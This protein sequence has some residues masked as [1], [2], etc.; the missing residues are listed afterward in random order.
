MLLELSLIS[1]NSFIPHGHCY[2]WKSNLVALHILSD[3]MIG[4]AYYVI[5]P[6]LIYFVRRREDLVFNWMFLLFGAF[7][8]ACGTT[9]FLEV[10]TLWH[11]NYWFT[12]SVKLLTGIISLYTAAKL[13]PLIP[14]ALELPS[15]KQMEIANKQLQQLNYELTEIKQDLEQRVVERTAELTDVVKRLEKE[16]K[17]RQQVEQALRESSARF[18][19][20]FD[21]NMIGIC[22]WKIDGEILEANDAFLNILGYSRNDFLIKKVSWLEFTAPEYALSDQKAL[23]EIAETGVASPYEKELIRVDG[24]RV[25]V[26]IGGSKLEGFTDTGVSFVLDITQRKEDERKLRQWADIFQYTG[27]GLVVNSPDSEVLQI[28]N[29]AFAA[30]HG[31]TVEEL[32]GKPIITIIAPTSL[33]NLPT[34]IHNAREKERYIFEELHVRK[35]GTTFPVLIDA[36]TVKD[37]NK[38]PIY[39]ILN[40]Q[41]IT[42]SKQAETEII[43]AL[44]TEKELNELKSRFIS[45]TS[46]EFRTPLA[47]I[48]SSAEL[49]EY[50]S[51]KLPESEQKSLFRQIETATTRMTGLLDDILIINKSESGKLQLHPT[52]VNLQKLCADLVTEIKLIASNKH[53]IIFT[54]TGNCINTVMDEKILR[55]ILTNL[56]GNAIKYSPDGGVIEFSLS[57]QNQQAIFQVKDNGIGIPEESQTQLFESFHR[58]SNVGNIQGTGLGLSIV[59]R[60]VDLSEGK[61]TFNSQ[62]GVGTTFTVILPLNMQAVTSTIL[63]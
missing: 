14:Q 60:M 51:H 9:H 38:K 54:H 57:C 49:L 58:A 19:H 37:N 11:P 30:M 7:I 4:L 28:L 24:S 33:P 40:F 1:N 45:L 63:E 56:L 20:I 27:Q 34:H 36:T 42:A 52:A 22:F 55:H 8:I 18:R 21:S 48:L 32:T 61:I 59:K 39:I 35:D 31:Y 17:Y 16:I 12:G 53:K 15:P 46:H 47:T 23:E 25:P 6:T 26:L 3:S 43:N 44:N 2:L 13:F 50:Y 62:V 10:W 5:P 29:P 41:D